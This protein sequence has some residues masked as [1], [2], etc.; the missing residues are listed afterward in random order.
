VS[1]PPPF[2]WAYAVQDAERQGVSVLQWWRDLRTQGPIEA[3]S[4]RLLAD[5]Q[6]YLPELRQVEGEIPEGPSVLG[7]ALQGLVDIRLMLTQVKPL[8]GKKDSEGR[9]VLPVGRYNAMVSQWMGWVSTL[10]WH[11]EEAPDREQ[12]AMGA[13]P[14]VTLGVIASV[15]AVAIC[16]TL[17]AKEI[18]RALAELRGIAEVAQN[19][20]KESGPSVVTLA[21]LGTAAVALATYTVNRLAPRG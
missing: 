4:T 3:T 2:T 11:V 15:V 13:L 16:I 12:P 10:A 19:T 6:T 5:A 7:S 21:A 14:V 18:P 1:L 20:V 17:T 8:V 9:V